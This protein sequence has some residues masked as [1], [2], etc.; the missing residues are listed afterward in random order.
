M[1]N[2]IQPFISLSKNFIQS[3][4]TM[5]SSLHKLLYTISSVTSFLLQRGFCLPAELADEILEQ[6]GAEI[7]GGGAGAGEAGENDV[8]EQFDKEDLEDPLEGEEA[9]DAK[10]EPKD[11]ED[12]PAVDMDDTA[13][14]GGQVED[15]DDQDD[16]ELDPQVHGSRL[17]DMEI[18]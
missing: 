16:N 18:T 7:G 10:N 17:F 15:V 1:I 2:L 8:S 14:Q 11:K 12:D 5:E 9:S 3:G 13:M 6:E 4:L